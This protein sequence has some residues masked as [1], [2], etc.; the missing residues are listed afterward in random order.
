M[1]RSKSF[2]LI[3]EAG[4]NGPAS[5]LVGNNGPA[6]GAPDGGAMLPSIASL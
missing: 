4:N 5:E 2:D 3:L 1:P 6:G